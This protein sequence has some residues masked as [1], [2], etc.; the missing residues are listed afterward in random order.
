MTPLELNILLHYRG[1]ADDFR[2]GDFSAPAVRSA[3]DWFRGDAGLLE[4][5]KQ[6]D[7]QNAAYKLTDKGMFFAEQLCMM[8]L[9]VSVWVMPAN[10]EITGSA[11]LRSPS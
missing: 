8:P 4:P 5:I 10:A 1:C 2:N 6:E 11:P 9:P 7:C 3:I